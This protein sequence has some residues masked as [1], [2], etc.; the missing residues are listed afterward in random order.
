MKKYTLIFAVYLLWGC[1]SDVISDKKNQTPSQEGAI[2]VV[3]FAMNDMHGKIDRFSKVKPFIDQA[4]AVSDKVFLVSAG[5]IFSGNPIVDF[6]PEKGSPIVSL[7]DAV[8]MDVSVLGNH[9]FDYGQAILNDRMSE[10]GFPFICANVSSDHA[11]LSVP[12]PYVVIEKGGFK[13]A[14]VGVVEN[15]SRGGLPLSHPKNMDGLAFEDGANAVANLSENPDII[16]ADLVVALTHYGKEEDRRLIDKAFNGSESFVDLVVGGHNHMLYNEKYRGIAMIQTGAHMQYMA[17]LTLS[18]LSGKVKSYQYELIDLSEDHPIDT[19]IASQIADFNN[20]PEFYTT[21]AIASHNYNKEETGCF[22]TT[23]LKESTES[24][25]AIQNYGGIRAQLQKGNIRPY[26][27][28]TIDPFGNGLETYSVRVSD[29][30]SFFADHF[31]MAY[32]GL[33][34]SKVAGQIVIKSQEGGALLADSTHI[35]IAVND[36]ISNLNPETFTT[37]IK[38]YDLTTADYLISYL[39]AQEQALDN[40]GCNRSID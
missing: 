5:D 12:D 2:E 7:M 27:V 20:R 11:I 13:I 34:I 39:K 15:S 23:A 24:E 28:Y 30:K 29:L 3:L 40:Q 6:H 37:L 17:K 35:K 16:G 9:E 14:F 26:D 25:L 33:H 1:G 4:R 22:Y 38:R 19:A 36:Y 31:S 8:G 18:V 21:L 10:A 32:S